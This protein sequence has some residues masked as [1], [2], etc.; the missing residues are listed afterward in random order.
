MR[1][2]TDETWQ[3]HGNAMAI[4]IDYPSFLPL[5]FHVSSMHVA[6]QYMYFIIY[7]E[8][9]WTFRWFRKVP[10]GRGNLRGLD[11][12]HRHLVLLNVF[13]GTWAHVRDD[14]G[15]GARR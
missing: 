8:R 11:V 7:K 12:S 3:D 2:V 6:Q 15:G 13:Q 1:K 4:P 9:K 14:L 5:P 10:D